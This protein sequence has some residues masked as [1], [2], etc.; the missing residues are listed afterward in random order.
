MGENFQTLMRTR[1]PNIHGAQKAHSKKTSR[2]LCQS[3]LSSSWLKWLKK[4]K[5]L[6]SSWRKRIYNTMRN[7]VRNDS[8]FLVGNDTHQKTA[9]WQPF[10][11]GKRTVVTL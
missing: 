8:I 3:T 2:T 7:E 4:K 9:V 11:C 1:N 10:K 6:K 5:F